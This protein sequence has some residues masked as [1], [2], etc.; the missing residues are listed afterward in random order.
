MFDDI[1]RYNCGTRVC[2]LVVNEVYEIRGVSSEIGH[3]IQNGQE[4]LV[5]LARILA[6][7]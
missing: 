5:A 6:E 7:R 1:K 2:V 3:E 4:P